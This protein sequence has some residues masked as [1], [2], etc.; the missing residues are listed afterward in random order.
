M[1]FEVVP[2][3]QIGNI[4]PSNVVIGLLPL[5]KLIVFC[6]DMYGSGVGSNRAGPSNKGEDECVAAPV[7]VYKV[8]GDDDEDVVDDLIDSDG[9]I[10]HEDGSECVENL[11]YAVEEEFIPG[12]V[13]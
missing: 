8:V 12:M 1:V 9:R 11:D 6:Y 5:Y 4:P 13:D 2:Q 7:V 10:L 3:I